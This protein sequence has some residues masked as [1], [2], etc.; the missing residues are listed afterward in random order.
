VQV[1]HIDADA[2]WLPRLIAAPP[3]ALIFDEPLATR[4]G[5]E[6]LGVLKR[7]GAT[8]R[9][10]V[11]MYALDPRTGRGALLELDYML[12]P[13]DAAELARAIDRQR[14]LDAQAPGARTILIVDDD[15]DTLA[16]HERLIRQQL[17]G[18][19]VLLARN[20]REA[21]ALL[22]RQRPDLMLLDLMMPELDGFGVL[23]AMRA[24]PETA[25][26]PVVVLTSRTLSEADL[27]RLNAGVAAILS[28]NLFSG[29]EIR[30]RIEAAL[31]RQRRL[32]SAMQQVVRRAMAFFHAHYAEP[33]TRDQLAL[34]LGVSA[35]HLTA[36]FRQEMGVTPIVYLN[37]YR[38]SRARALLETSSRSVTEIAMA[39][40]FT[41]LAHF[42]RTFHR[43]VGLTPNAYRRARPPSARK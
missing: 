1:Q 2:N 13:L 14:E 6:L 20:G 29:D 8:A 36:S 33:I 37:R 17:P 43:E 30:E 7:H 27:E 18:C 4:R 26:L 28:K 42:S 39:V 24:R 31:S 25:D 40:G 9:L 21:L 16:L 11:L 15:P 35:D 10:P 19:R 12:K 34:H 41:D 32:S 38:I 22:S 5:W 3:D 23:E